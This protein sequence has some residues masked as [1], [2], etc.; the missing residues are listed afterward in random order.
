MGEAAT[1]QL[2]TIRVLIA[3]D[4]AGAREA[5]AALIDAEASLALVGQ[6]ADAAQAIHLAALHHPDVA[7]VDVRMPLGGGSRATREI[8]LCS[9]GTKIIALSFYEDRATVLEMIRAGAEGYLVKGGSPR[10]IIEAIHS[11]ARG[12]GRLSDRVTRE[13]VQELAAQ[14]KREELSAAWRHLRAQRV[15]L[16]I[17]GVGVRLAFQPIVD[18]GESRIIGVEGLARFSGTGPRGPSG[19]LGMGDGLAP[20]RLI[21]P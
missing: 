18:L 11:S 5:L 2:D 6:A 13:V 4:D 10:E 8:R 12:D 14:L 9:P 21:V 19:W 3:E 7:L 16:L 1:Q 15:R 20:P 17:H